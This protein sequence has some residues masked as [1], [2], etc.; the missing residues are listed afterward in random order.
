MTAEIGQADVFISHAHE[1]KEV[2]QPLAEALRQRGLTV[3]YDEYVLQLGDSLREV[4]E[5][6]LATARFG[7]V[8]WNAKV[9]LWREGAKDPVNNRGDMVVRC[10]RGGSWNVVAR[11]LAAAFRLRSKASS[12]SRSFGFRC[13]LPSRVEP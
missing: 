3:W 7:V 12:Q 1:D 11:F 10:L 13:V 8:M 4:I 5:R 2:A 6:G 9:Y